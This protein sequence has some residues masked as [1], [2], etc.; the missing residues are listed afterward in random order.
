MHVLRHAAESTLF[1]ATVLP[2]VAK[3]GI[4]EM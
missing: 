3:F 1:C 4:A 2:P